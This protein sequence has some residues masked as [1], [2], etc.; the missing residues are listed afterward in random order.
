MP[1]KSR[2][3][4]PRRISGEGEGGQPRLRNFLGVDKNVYMCKKFRRYHKSVE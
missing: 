3:D 4:P 2:G 1:T